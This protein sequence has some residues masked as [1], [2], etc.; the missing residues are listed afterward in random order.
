MSEPAKKKAVI[1]H[2]SATTLQSLEDELFEN[3]MSAL[4]HYQIV[5]QGYELIK[6][7]HDKGVSGNSTDRPAFNQ[8]LDDLK[9]NQDDEP[10]SVIVSD[11]SHLARD[12][13]ILLTMRDKIIQAGG[14]I[15]SPDQ[16][17]HL[18]MMEAS[19]SFWNSLP[20]FTKLKF[21]IFGRLKHFASNG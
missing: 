13:Q 19:I 17:F 5:E 3:T 12:E 8:M 21:W 11:L 6:A 4:Q 16:N 14:C 15:A 2:R 10:V 20:W 18:N 1:Y 7:Y 9:A